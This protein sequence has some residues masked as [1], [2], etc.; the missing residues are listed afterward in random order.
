MIAPRSHQLYRNIVMT[1]YKNFKFN[2]CIIIRYSCENYQ[3]HILTTQFWLKRIMEVKCLCKIIQIWLEPTT[4]VLQAYV[5]VH[6]TNVLIP[7]GSL[8]R[9]IYCYFWGIIFTC[10]TYYRVMLLVFCLPIYHLPLSR[11]IYNTMN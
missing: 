10:S 11:S 7:N 5:R 6:L 2:R 9:T 1:L 8:K 3:N 4:P